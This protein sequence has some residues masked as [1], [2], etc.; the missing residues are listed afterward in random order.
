MFTQWMTGLSILAIAILASPIMADELKVG[1]KAP[2][3]SLDGEGAETINL[4]DFKGKKLVITFN[5]A[6]WCPF[7]MKQVVDLQKHYDAI[8]DAGAELLIIWREEAT[9]SDGLKKIRERTKATMPF[10]LDLEAQKT[11]AYSPEGFDAYIV[12]EEGKIIAIL[13]GTKPDRAMGDAIIE[14]LKQD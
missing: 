3:F 10:A 5:R 1:D 6:N 9:G 4:R 14:K 7:C 12:D 2:D 8:R 13:E 11:G